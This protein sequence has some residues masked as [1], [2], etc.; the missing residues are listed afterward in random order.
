[1]AAAAAGKP[2]LLLC[3]GGGGWCK[4]CSCHGGGWCSGAGCP[5]A[6]AV[7]LKWI[8]QT[9]TAAV[10]EMVV[11]WCGGSEVVLA[12]V[13]TPRGCG[14]EGCSGGDVV[15]MVMMVDMVTGKWP[16]MVA[17]G[18]DG[19]CGWQRLPWWR[20]AAVHGEEGIYYEEVFAPVARIKAIQLFLAYASFMGF[21]VYQMDV[22]SAFLYGTI[23]E[24]VYVCQPPGFKDPDYLDKRG[25]I[26]QTLFLKKDSKYIILVQV[27]VDDIIFG[28][29]RQDWSDEFEALM[30]SQFE[31]SSIG[32]LT[33][34]LGLQVD[35]RSDGIFIHQTKYVNDILHK[36]DMDTNK[37]APTPFEPPKIKDKNLPDGPVN[38]HIYRSMI[39][40]LMYLT[41]SR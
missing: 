35:Q 6:A 15:T 19:C 34:F 4:W 39:G 32:Q 8:W 31:M 16:E 37:S 24:E 5:R 21:M 40:S 7:E 29:T 27:Y 3:R 1:M 18:S 41:A 33:F 36:F 9:A 12:V 26:D 38:V 30:Q 25:T 11:T 2:P 28:S 17:G 14:V 10:E 20:R 13:M 22:R 23:E